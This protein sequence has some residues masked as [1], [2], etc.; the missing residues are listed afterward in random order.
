MISGGVLPLE[1]EE[2]RLA[3]R[4]VA[5]LAEPSAHR[6]DRSS[7]LRTLVLLIEPD[8]NLY[9]YDYFIRTVW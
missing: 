2:G 1:V 6:F 8:N 3:R 7:G 4:V 5:I 9:L